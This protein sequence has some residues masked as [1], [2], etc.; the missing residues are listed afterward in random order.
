MYNLHK[1]ENK[2]HN[3]LYYFHH[4]KKL[5]YIRSLVGQKICQFLYIKYKQLHQYIMHIFQGIFGRVYQ[6][7]H[8]I[9][10]DK[11]RLELLMNSFFPHTLS[12]QWEKNITYKDENKPHILYQHFQSIHQHNYKDVQ[13]FCSVK[14]CKLNIMSMKCSQH[15][16]GHN[17][18]ILHYPEFQNKCLDICMSEH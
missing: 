7:L 5:G 8:N 10:L 12:K 13:L 4:Q 14:L 1:G 3:Q 15:K 9:H 6:H 16:G 11:D 2:Q 18:S 17:F